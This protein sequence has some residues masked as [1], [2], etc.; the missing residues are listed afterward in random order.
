MEMN[1]QMPNQRKKQIL[2]GLLITALLIACSDSSDTNK[3]TP[4]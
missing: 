2:C 4:P 3:P 1:K